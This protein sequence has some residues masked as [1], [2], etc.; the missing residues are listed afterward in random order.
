MV[1]F[2]KNAGSGP[3]RNNGLNNAN[4]EYIVFV[5]PD[6]WVAPTMVEELLKSMKEK[7]V[8]FVTSGC[9]TEIYSGDRFIN[10]IE[11]GFPEQIILSSENLGK[12]YFGLFNIGAISAPT[13][14]IYKRSIIDRNNIEFPD[15]RRSQ[16]IVFNYRYYQHIESV[17]V[18]PNAYYYYRVD[19]KAN[20]GKIKL[21]Y[22]KSIAFIFKDIKNLCLLWEIDPNDVEYQKFCL[23]FFVALE[24]VLRLHNDKQSIAEVVGNEYIQQLVDE[25]QVNTTKYK[26]LKSMIKNKHAIAISIGMKLMCLKSN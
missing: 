23:H 16:D 15:L 9:I 8:D 1:L 24:L 18:S 19:M 11:D 14:K 20:Q 22:Y 3:A 4:G 25:V 21:S 17:Y 13:K 12:S 10:E 7:D 2:Q 6:D 5:D 26:I